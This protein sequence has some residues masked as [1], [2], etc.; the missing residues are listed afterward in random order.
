M[1]PKT[2]VFE[3]KRV[4]AYIDAG[5]PDGIQVDKFGNVYSSCKDGVHVSCP[6]NILHRMLRASLGLESSRYAHW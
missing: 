1:N 2:Q 3:R 4:F 5:T 6:H